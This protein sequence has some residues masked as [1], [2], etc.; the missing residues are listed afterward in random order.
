[1][2]GS[3]RGNHDMTADKAWVGLTTENIRD[4]LIALIG[5]RFGNSEEDWWNL[6]FDPARRQVDFSMVAG[7]VVFQKSDIKREKQ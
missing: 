2:I 1:M 3:S 6:P 7:E 4:M 5:F